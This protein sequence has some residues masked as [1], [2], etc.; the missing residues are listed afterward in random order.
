MVRRI[1]WVTSGFLLV[2]AACC[3]EVFAADADKQVN[4]NIWTDTDAVLVSDVTVGNSHV[5]CYW[6]PGPSGKYEPPPMFR[7]GDGGIPAGPR[8]TSMLQVCCIVTKT[9]RSFW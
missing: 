5:Q 8:S 3:N 9:K 1:P 2:L 7:G 6:S 4:C